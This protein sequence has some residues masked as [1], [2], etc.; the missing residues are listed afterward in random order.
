MVCDRC[1]N[2]NNV[3]NSITGIG[4]FGSMIGSL[5]STCCTETRES[6]YQKMY[7]KM[8]QAHN[9]LSQYMGHSH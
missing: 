9:K 4:K 2:D 5:Y 7:Q 3:H 8:N 1:K 6:L